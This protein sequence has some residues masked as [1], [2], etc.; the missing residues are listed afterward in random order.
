MF[1]PSR[2]PFNTN[3]CTLL[4]L[5]WYLTLSCENL[6]LVAFGLHPLLYKKNHKWTPKR[7]V[8][9]L[10]ILPTGRGVCPKGKPWV[11]SQQHIGTI[12]NHL[13]PSQSQVFFPFIPTWLSAANRL[14]TWS[15]GT[16][17]ISIT[18]HYHHTHPCWLRATCLVATW[19]LSSKRPLGERTSRRKASCYIQFHA[20]F[21]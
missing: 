16:V 9:L 11:Q 8:N 17:K 12:W 19:L 4:C 6:S 18:F 13:E 15:D 3:L 21:K 2:L 14:E 10:V 1:H 20:E 7:C 5:I